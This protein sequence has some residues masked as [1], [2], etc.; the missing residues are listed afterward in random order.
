M[1]NMVIISIVWAALL[2]GADAYFFDGTYYNAFSSMIGQIFL[3]F[4]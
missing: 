2:Y 1:K 3:S 4:H